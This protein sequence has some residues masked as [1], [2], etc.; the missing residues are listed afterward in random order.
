MLVYDSF[1]GHLEQSVKEKF[2]ESGIHLMVIPGGLTSICQP[3]DVSINK[4][5]KDNLRKEWHTWMASGGAEETAAGNLRRASFS[6]VC[7]WVKHAWE[8]ISTEVIFESFKKCKISND[9]GLDSEV[10]DDSISDS[11]FDDHD[12]D[13][14]DEI[15]DDDDE[16]IDDEI[17][18]D[19][20]IIDDKEV[21]DDNFVISEDNIM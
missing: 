14:D 18:D 10:S 20:E 13:D 17:D 9:L 1:S 2:H 12:I 19:D 21:I 16:I 5:F 7:L 11:D 4:P 6:D 3:L 15:D 8:G